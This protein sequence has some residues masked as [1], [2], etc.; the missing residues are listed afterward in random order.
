MLLQGTQQAIPPRW[1]E[2]ETE[3]K[4]VGG[5]FER[6]LSEK[7]PS[8]ENLQ[9]VLSQR[10]DPGSDPQSLPAAS[11]GAASL[12]RPIGSVSEWSSMAGG[13]PLRRS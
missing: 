1:L 10:S 7:R 11:S 9:A 13:E 6:A 2:P 4:E 5:R 8:P 3:R 12:E